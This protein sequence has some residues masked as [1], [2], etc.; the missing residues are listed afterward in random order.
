[1]TLQP[2]DTAPKD[3]TWVLLYGGEVCRFDDDFC[4]PPPVVVGRFIEDLDG[5]YGDRWIFAWYDGGYYG[6]YYEPTH[7]AP[8]PDVV[9]EA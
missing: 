4:Q 7:W 2:I 8:L 3:G 1:M 5:A 9:D 6:E